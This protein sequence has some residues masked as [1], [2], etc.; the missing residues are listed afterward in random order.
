M[1]RERGLRSD[2][3]RVVVRQEQLFKT[4]QFP[5]D[6]LPDPVQGVIQLQRSMTG[7][8]VLDPLDL[9]FEVP[10]AIRK[11]GDVARRLDSVDHF[12]PR[13]LAIFNE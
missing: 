2:H 10:Q 8:A 12:P 1:L 7:D 5:S 9:A 4:G 6:V 13:V 11:A 3:I